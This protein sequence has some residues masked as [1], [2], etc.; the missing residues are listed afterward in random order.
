MRIASAS[1][2]KVSACYFA[3]SSAGK[4][5]LSLALLAGAVSVVL[6]GPRYKTWPVIKGL[7]ADS[8][9]LQVDA[10]QRRIQDST[11]KSIPS[12]VAI[13]RGSGAGSG[14]IITANG[15]I[16]TQR[17]VVSL[18]FPQ[19][20]PGSKVAVRLASG[21]ETDGQ[22][23]GVD[24]LYD[25]AA[26]QLTRPGPYPHSEL[27][28][29]SPQLGEE[30]LKLGYPIG[31][32]TE[33]RPPVVRF[34]RVLARTSDH[35]ICD[36][37][38]NGG[39]SGGPF[40]NLDGRVVGL[41]GPPGIMVKWPNA[42]QP[43]ERHMVDQ[44]DARDHYLD[45]G[46]AAKLL[47][48]RLQSLTQPATLQATESD[49]DAKRADELALELAPTLPVELWCQGA[50]SLGRF[51]KTGVSDCVVEVLGCDGQVIALGT[52]IDSA[53]L[54][55]TAAAPIVTESKC[56]LDKLH[57]RL[58]DRSA[59][60]AAVIG[61]DPN[62]NLALMRIQAAGLKPVEWASAHD[63]P[64]GTLVAAVGPKKLPLVA[65][66]VSVARRQVLH[67]HPV[68][69]HDSSVELLETTAGLVPGHRYT[70]SGFERNGRDNV[71]EAELQN[72]RSLAQVFYPPDG[73]EADLPIL[74]TEHG[75]PVVGHEGKV[76][77]VTVGRIAPQA[78]IIVPT[79]RV[80]ACLAKLKDQAA[81]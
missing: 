34:C 49:L 53:G 21:A 43:V 11:R 29:E 58:P 41:Q 79:D 61:I 55:L 45:T 12:V 59:R 50:H 15:L 6:V 7:V 16:L 62:Y 81:R 52:V 14:V 76:L 36:C 47:H 73:F 64:A 28:E 25:L 72:R 40:I 70:G 67:P 32:P 74:P 33:G 78:C 69:V 17:H 13:G 37:L 71:V 24:P 38:V 65:G 44:L 48:R 66:V 8:E 23:L 46:R 57:C 4:I 1:V 19:A 30:L 10:L 20:T 56:Y 18:S 35:F 39:D 9:D 77:G 3:M 51:R 75:C 42:N 22:L 54:V 2:S 5:A 60:V 63:P 68:R 80:L 27:A 31:G 26:L